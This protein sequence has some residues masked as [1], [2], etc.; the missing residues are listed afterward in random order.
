M[1][2]SFASLVEKWYCD[3]SCFN[4]VSVKALPRFPWRVPTNWEYLYGCVYMLPYPLAAIRSLHFLNL[5]PSTF[6]SALQVFK[7]CRDFSI[8]VVVLC[9]KKS[10]FVVVLCPKK[11]VSQDQRNV[12]RT[13]RRKR[14]RNCPDPRNSSRSKHETTE[15]PGV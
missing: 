5:K 3:T 8:F 4:S 12:D 10:I 13:N 15:N 2:A 9:P 6:S 11:S 1:G 7:L 14:N